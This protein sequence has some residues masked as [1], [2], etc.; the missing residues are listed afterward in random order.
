MKTIAVIPARMGAQ[1]FPGKPLAKE[2]GK[3]LVQHV[4][5]AAAQCSLLDRVIVATDDERIVSAVR[6]F[7]GEVAMT[8]P[9]HVSGTDRVGEVAAELNLAP[10]DMVLNVQGDEPE[11]HPDVLSRLI[12]RFRDLPADCGSSAPRIGTI[13]VPFSDSGPAEGPN[14]PSDPNRVKVVL[15]HLGNAMYFSRSLIPFPRN[16]GGKVDRPSRWLL[17]LGVYA[18]RAD[19]LSLITTPGRL[20][21]GGLE[22]TESLEQL[23]WLH[24]GLPIAVAIV[25]HGFAGVDTP[26][27]YAGFVRRYR[28]RSAA[29][30]RL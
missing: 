9:D 13:A 21:R 3:Y 15:D 29:S 10:D 7:D 19:V 5:E 8:R 17:H 26:E 28:N 12:A 1:R 6:S 24:A 20:P 22:D 16:S 4:Y 14:S 11:L 27:D 30:Q 23:R 2:T 18:F 25:G